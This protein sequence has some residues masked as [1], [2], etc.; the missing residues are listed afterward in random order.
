MGM[1]AARS[2]SPC[3]KNSP[4]TRSAHFSATALGLT[5][6]GGG[7]GS[8]EGRPW[9][10]HGVQPGV[11]GQG[12]PAGTERWPAG[13]ATS[14]PS[15]PIMPPQHHALGLEMSAQCSR[16]LSSSCRSSPLSNRRGRP[17]LRA[18]KGRPSWTLIA[19][20]EAR[21]SGSRLPA[22]RAPARPHD[23]AA[24]LTAAGRGAARGGVP[25]CWLC[26]ARKTPRACPPGGAGRG[27][28][29]A[30]RGVRGGQRQCG[31]AACGA[32]TGAPAWRAQ[33]PNAHHAPPAYHGEVVH[34]VC[35]QH[36]PNHHLAD[37][38]GR[39][40]R[41]QGDGTG[42]R[43]AV[44]GTARQRRGGGGGGGGCHGGGIPARRS[45]C[46]ARPTAFRLPAAA[47]SPH[48]TAPGRDGQ[49]C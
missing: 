14:R 40:G 17:S 41:Q 24:A 22:P 44:P 31:T 10:A 30:R 35:G 15:C 5:A 25:E 49:R 23:P 2:R 19:W 11:A 27:V 3:S 32:G 12:R 20:Q 38:R 18:G 45:A 33:H 8:G 42:R 21:V 4:S 6:G 13:A 34:H 9:E 1:P 28:S 47:R 16:R 36:R 26:A 48:A 37:L 43:L 46:G 39:G 7:A 29:G